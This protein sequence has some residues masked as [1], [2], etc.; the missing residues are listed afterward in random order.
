MKLCP[1]CNL[2]RLNSEVRC[3][4]GYSFQDDLQENKSSDVSQHTSAKKFYVSCQNNTCLVGP[5]DI[6]RIRRQIAAGTLS[7][8]DLVQLDGELT[9]TPLAVFFASVGTPNSSNQ[10][11]HS[12]GIKFDRVSTTVSA[13]NVSWT[14]RIADY[15]AGL[16][17]IVALNLLIG[18]GS[19]VG[20]VVGYTVGLMPLLKDLH[21][22]KQT[23]ATK[24][25][26][27]RGLVGF[28]CCGLAGAF[29][30]L[31][32]SIPTAG[33]FWWLIT[34]NMKQPQSQKASD[35]LLYIKSRTERFITVNR[36]L[37]TGIF[38]GIICYVGKEMDSSRSWFVIAPIAGL[39][40]LFF[41]IHDN[42][43]TGERLELGEALAILAMGA[44]LSLLC[45]IPVL[46]LF[47]LLTGIAGN[48]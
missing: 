10:H 18:L 22:Q 41:K 23:S 12:S 25:N 14:V 30:G 36:C 13:K 3:E 35:A 43:A 32:G 47:A 11:P 4:C 42:E 27:W 39:P 40:W 33:L 48:N 29:A 31:I 8:E 16:A 7:G 20:A 17:I 19:R 6:D 21:R 38:A 15:A 44:F 28:I 46:L 34:R 2:K 1:Q 24:I 45:G 37:I 9:W 5:Y 26:L